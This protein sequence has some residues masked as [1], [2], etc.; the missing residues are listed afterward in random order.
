MK[1]RH[2]VLFEATLISFT[3]GGAL[4]D[5]TLPAA[6]GLV[7]GLSA[8][9]QGGAPS[10]FISDVVATDFS[11]LVSSTGVPVGSASAS[12]VIN[13]ADAAI[14]ATA[15]G[16]EGTP[17]AG[18]FYSAGGES[19]ES[20]EYDFEVASPKSGIVDLNIEARGGFVIPAANAGSFSADAQADL[21]IVGG[22]GGL[23]PLS[24]SDQAFV[25]DDDLGSP[26]VQAS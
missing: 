4:A 19:Y 5:T 15:T 6:Y 18:Q 12:A 1:L 13:A 22:T 21:Y 7:G 25:G 20:F 10:P 11:E 24:I 2:F 3:I 9:A 23:D 16:T 17:P 14:S 8:D 26:D